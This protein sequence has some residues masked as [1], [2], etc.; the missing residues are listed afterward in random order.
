MKVLFLLMFPVLCFGQ[1]IKSNQN[2]GIMLAK[3][4]ATS[5]DF[6]KNSNYFFNVFEKYNLKDYKR[7]IEIN[8]NITRAYYSSEISKEYLK[9]YETTKELLKTII[10]L[11]N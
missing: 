6:K 4:T 5:S 11:L 2:L 9:D 3:T 7:D 10:E 8:Q 1:S